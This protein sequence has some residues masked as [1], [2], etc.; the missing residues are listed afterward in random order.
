MELFSFGHRGGPMKFLVLGPLAVEGV[1]GPLEMG[2]PRQRSVLA[3][4]LVAGGDVVSVDRLLVD[5][6]SGEPPRRAVGSLQ[7]FVSNLRRT[8]EPD[9]APRS[10]AQRLVSS[11]PGYLLRVSEDDEIDSVAFERLVGEGSRMLAH[12]RPDEA[13]RALDTALALWRGEA[14]AGFAHEAWAAPEVARLAELRLLARE[15][16]MAAALAAGQ[17]A[18]A[19]PLIESLAR[20]HPLR[21]GLWRLLCLALYRTGRQAEA[22]GVLLQAREL[23]ASE[24]GHDPTPA[25]QLLEREVL[26]QAP[27]LDWT[28]P[29]ASEPALTIPSQREPDPAVGPLGGGIPIGRAAPLQVLLTAAGE[30]LAGGV[31]VAVVAGESGIGKTFLADAVSERL[32]AGGWRIA[33]GRCTQ[34]EGVPALWP[35][36]QVLGPLASAFPAAPDIAGRL[37]N[38]LG[39]ES[40][41]L[42]ESSDGA[43]ARFRQHDA[44]A[45]HLA[46]ATAKEPLLIVLDDLQWADPAS[47]RL[48]LDLIALRRGG[49]ILVIATLRSGEESP[50]LEDALGRLARDGA[51]RL[52]LNGL[53]S[54]AV[55]ELSACLGL[56]LDRS[57]VA[58]LAAR[59][60][61]NPFLVQE[62]VRVA[63][64]SGTGGAEALLAGAPPTVRDVLQRRL[65]RLPDATRDLLATAAVLG[66]DVD[67]ELLSAVTF[68]PEEQLLDGLDLAA[69]HG[70]LAQSGQGRLRFAHDLVRETL[71][72]DLGSVR[73]MRV[74][75]RATQ[76]LEARGGDSATIAFHALAAGASESRRAAHFTYAAGV[77]AR[78]QLA[79]DD[80]AEWF[81]KAIDLA[82]AEPEPDWAAIVSVQLELIR[83]QLDT[84]DWISARQTRAAAIRAADLSGDPD[85]ALRALVEMDAPTVWTLHG[86]A[87]VD[88]DIARRTERALAALPEADSALRCRLLG[89]LAA[90]LYDG[91]DDPRC[92][93][94]SIEAVEMARRLGDPRLLAVALTCRCQ[95][96]NQP[97][98]AAELVAVGQELIELGAQEG[99]PA[100]ELLG[101]EVS[102]V[103]R[104][105]LFD[106]GGADADAAAGEPLL[107]KLSHRPATAIHRV[108]H[109]MRLLA[110]GR[111][112]EAGE[113]YEQ[114]MAEQLTLGFS[115]TEPLGEVVR[116]MLDTTRERWDAVT[117]RLDALEAVSP[118]FAHSLRVWALAESGRAP[119]ARSLIDAEN[120]AVLHDWSELTLLAAAAQA[121]V[122]AGHPARMHWCY[123]RL[124]PYSG[125]LA[126]GGNSLVLGP[127]D[128]YLAQLANQLGDAEAGEAHRARAESDCREAGLLWWAERSQALAREP[129]VAP[130]S[131]PTGKPQVVR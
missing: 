46:I 62:S 36:Q 98:F 111:L 82:Q 131:A 97:R 24:L 40:S 38:L 117:E 13:G 23:L 31:R 69:V 124:L 22:L 127:V 21:E 129:R 5:L 30:A 93:T 27:E 126:V 86:Y 77:C 43:E 83:V 99:M 112:A 114:S 85:L 53:D 116:A 11:A 3:R 100:Y 19:V 60:A 58:Q 125:W 89:T 50:F 35:W 95:A 73:R 64:A 61:G 41:P 56:A 120:P 9:R 59:T 6:W 39:T 128:F 68:E 14:Y 34:A 71:E 67:P 106:V 12:G 119:E 84:G 94:L 4:L 88:L 16:R 65:G 51:L 76:A 72:S 17:A 110:D 32:H 96:V 18:E 108:W 118:L 102:A 81:T 79:F 42:A 8:L 66:R 25:A 70:V 63:G 74:H 15:H 115:R 26:A 49:R 107:R 37:S 105:Q 29:R 1:S 87:E 123:E 57:Q 104:M 10:P 103:S 47:L 44:V 20:E 92:D 52:S 75:S 113:A 121:S 7:T 48:L 2:G 122:A 80:A 33:W 55:A 101:H 109:A 90:Q 28:P 54:D 78:Q 130:T 45:R 91:S